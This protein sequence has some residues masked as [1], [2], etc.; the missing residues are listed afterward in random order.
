[1]NI[2]KEISSSVQSAGLEGISQ[3]IQKLLIEGKEDAPIDP[4]ALKRSC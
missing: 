3:R 2:E 4:G 1:M